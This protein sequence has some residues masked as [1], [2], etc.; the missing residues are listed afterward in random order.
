MV[1]LQGKLSSVRVRN[2]GWSFKPLDY[3]DT[4]YPEVSRIR[5]FELEKLEQCSVAF[6]QPGLCLI[7]N[8]SL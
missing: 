5:G 8:V 4:S 3:K 6:D 2:R 1:S 7:Q